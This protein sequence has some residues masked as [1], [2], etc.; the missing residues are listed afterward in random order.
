MKW[1]FVNNQFVEKEKAFIFTNDLAIQRGYAAFDYLR[2]RDHKPL[3]LD[4]YL[5][6]FFNSAREMFINI[7][8]SKE[9]V[10]EVILQLI[11]R[12][13][14]PESG[15]RLVATGGYSPDSYTPVAGNLIINQ[16][17]ITLISED[18]FFAGVKIMTHEYMRDLPGVKSINYLMG[19]WLQQ[20][21][22]AKQLDDVLYYH[23]GIVTEFP[24]ANVFIV[25]KEG[26]LVTPAQNVL[27]GITRKRILEFGHKLV[28]TVM[29]DIHIDELRDAAEVFMTSTTK[30][31]LPIVEIDGKPVGAGK[32]GS[33][34]ILLNQKFLEV[35]EEYLRSH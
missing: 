23:N 32:V 15:I 20:Q 12:N 33:V 30:R 29:R 31:I 6:R 1:V 4:D 13:G 35:E 3:F 28:P 24:R 26:E 18:K 25:T 27:E 11:E 16:E 8:L 7:P 5:T 2:T 22:R 17:P 34:S 9:A 19:I 21:L 10:K 14:M